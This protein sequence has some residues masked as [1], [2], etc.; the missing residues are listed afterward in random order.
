MRPLPA[1]L[2]FEGGATLP[3]TGMAAWNMLVTAGGH[4]VHMVGTW[5][6]HGAHGG[7]VGHRGTKSLEVELPI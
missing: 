3:Y 5:S 6:A 2:S 4:M 7:H 1:R